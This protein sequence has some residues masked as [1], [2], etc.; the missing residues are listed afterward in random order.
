M[1]KILDQMEQWR[2]LTDSP[3]QKII[4][5]QERLMN[6]ATSPMLKMIEQQNEHLR[7][8]T[9]P[10]SSKFSEIAEWQ[11]TSDL[12]QKAIDSQIQ[13]VN[14][15]CEQIQQITGPLLKQADALNNTAF[16]EFAKVSALAEDSVQ[17]SLSSMAE[18]LSAFDPVIEIQQ[19]NDQ[20][21]QIRQITEP[22]L[23]QADALN[24]TAIHEFVKVSGLAKDSIEKGLSSMVEQVTAFDPVIREIQKHQSLI[25]AMENPAM[26]WFRNQNRLQE[27]C[28]EIEPPHFVEPLRIPFPKPKPRRKSPAELFF[29]QVR[30]AIRRSEDKLKDDECLVVYCHTQAGEIVFVQRIAFRNPH[31]IILYGFDTDG[32][33]RHVFAHLKTVQLHVRIEKNPDSEE[34]NNRWIQ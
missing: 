12:A 24:N 33:D 4:E 17:K 31:L 18:Q 20:W 3:I 1:R 29:R 8:M 26:E 10:L 14:D 25:S 16:Y 6:L 30:K 2:R 28:R 32:R 21:E 5:Q 7:R 15:Q 22:L 13:Q 27:L 9:E 11:K 23:K 19:M 34:G